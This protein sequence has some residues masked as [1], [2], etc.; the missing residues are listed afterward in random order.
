VGRGREE[1]EREVKKGRGEEDREW[2]RGGEGVGKRR[3]NGEES[4]EGV[5][6]EGWGRGKERVGRREGERECE[7]G[8]GPL[9]QNRPAKNLCEMMCEV[10]RRRGAGPGGEG[11]ERH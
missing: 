10:K 11:G 9:K 4:G 5:G 8:T 3:G 6:K 7:I 1:R 2:G